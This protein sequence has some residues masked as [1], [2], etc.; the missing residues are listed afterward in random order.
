MRIDWIDGV[1][2]LVVV[3]AV[4]VM[5]CANPIGASESSRGLGKS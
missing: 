4:S 3:A 1:I 5:L 2:L